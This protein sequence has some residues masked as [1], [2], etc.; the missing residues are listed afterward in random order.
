MKLSQS[1]LDELKVFEGF[2][3]NAYIPVPGD[4]PTIGYGF[5]KGVDMGDTMTLEEAEHRLIEEVRPYEQA[6]A[7][8]CT[9]RPNQNEFDAMVLLCY[10]IG[11]AGFRRSSV[12]K[13][14]NRGDKPAASR[15][16]GLWNKSGGKE[17][18]GLT[19]RRGLEGARY[20]KPSS[21]APIAEVTAA[22]P[23]TVDSESSM[24]QSPINRA[25]VV[26]GGTAA[27]TA[28]AEVARTATDVKSSVTFLGDWLVPLLLVAVVALCGYI[29]WQRI[30][31][32]KE[33]WT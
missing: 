19:R 8:A 21:G 20:L 12:L 6:V 29:V 9:L 2:R 23:Q 30:N 11:I 22:M 26:A 27:V 7:Q 14:H 3:P 4:V 16:F 10:N 17:Y 25:G 32:R 13:A 31:Q 24:G 5:T 18:A 1:A 15:A 33:G 28:V